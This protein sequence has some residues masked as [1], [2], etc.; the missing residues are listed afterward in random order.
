M[1]KN[2][3]NFSRVLSKKDVLALAFGAMIGWGWIVLAGD[4]V[5]MAGTIGAILAFVLGGI[6]VVF[7]GLT[8]A[9]LTSAMP[10]CGGE[11][12]FTLR[13]LGYRMSFICTWAIILG[14]VSVVAFEAVAF[15]TVLEY[16]VPSYVKGYMYSVAGYDIY[17]TWVLVAVVS[18]MLITLVNYVGV[19]PAAVMQSIFTIVIAVVGLSFFGGTLANGSFENVQPLFNNGSSGLLSVLVMTPFLFVGFDVIPQAAEEI[20]LPFKQIGRILIL[21]VVLAIFWYIMIIFGVSLAMP[22]AEM[23]KS[24]LIT[25]DAMKAVFGH[26]QL[27]GNIMICAGIGGILTSWNSFF[28]GGSRAMYS[29][30]ESGMLPSVFA[31]LHPKYKTP[32]NAILLIGGISTLAP[33]LGRSMLVWV[34]DA[35]GLTIV[36]SYFLVSLSFLRLRYKEPDMSR[37]YTVKYGKLVGYIAC[38]L[39]ATMAILYMPGMPSALAWPYEWLIII[40]WFALGGIFWMVSPKSEHLTH[41][42]E[43]TTSAISSEA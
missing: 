13:A 42:K 12:V 31:K 16:L 22:S 25:A 29:M 35:G 30:A 20:D 43:H 33:L 24:A 3:S 26:S 17:L 38:I 28:V 18:S 37:P 2:N 6:L 36:I 21:S 39:T 5:M 1:S 19:K 34:V 40:L 10:K 23:A 14:Y 27:A 11:H 15:P 41:K 8:Y 32:T 9:E 4:W 7:V